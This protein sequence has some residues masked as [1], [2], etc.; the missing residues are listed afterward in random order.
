MIRYPS[1][2]F[3]RRADMSC[4]VMGQP[5]VLGCREYMRHAENVRGLSGTL[6]FAELALVG[7]SGPLESLG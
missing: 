2:E 7:E 6:L 5:W 4:D 1:H 3:V